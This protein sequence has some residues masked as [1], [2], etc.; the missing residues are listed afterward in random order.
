MTAITRR[1]VPKVRA[2]GFPLSVAMISVQASLC[3]LPLRSS[4]LSQ[5]SCTSFSSV[6]GSFS[7]D[8][9]SAIS[10]Q[11]F[12]SEELYAGTLVFSSSGI[13]YCSI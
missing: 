4:I 2:I 7:L 12:E 9:L 5:S 13:E 6:E 10:R 8:A 11:P 3:S 1:R